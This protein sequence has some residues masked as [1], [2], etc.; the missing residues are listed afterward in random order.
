MRAGALTYTSLF[1]IVPLL[2]ITATI[3]SSLPFSENMTFLLEDF[4]AKNF[5][6]HA[7]S[8]IS[9]YISQ[10]V[11]QA[12]KLT[13]FGGLILVLTVMM[14]FRNVEKTF[15]NIWAVGNRRKK[16]WR[17]ATYVMV[18]VVAPLLL[19]LSLSISSM[20]FSVSFHHELSES[21]GINQLLV[22]VVNLLIAIPAF[23]MMYVAIPATHV[24][25]RHGAVGAVTV[26]FSLEIVKAGFGYFVKNFTSYDYVYGAFSVFPLF[27]LWI[28]VCWIIIL[29]GVVLVHIQGK[30]TKQ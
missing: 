22:R 24:S 9:E 16:R 21:I 19:A 1:A 10:F 2:T 20:M 3:F 30:L 18:A 4:L 11:S 13:V 23:F 12:K 7:G 15:N 29:S 8:Q 6:P 26:G 28:Y 14:L 25:V 27:L 17:F 5:I